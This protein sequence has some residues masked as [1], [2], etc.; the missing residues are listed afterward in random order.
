MERNPNKGVKGAAYIARS[1]RELGAARSIVATADGEVIA[2]N[3]V[4]E[5]AEKLGI[6]TR[7]VQTDGSE[8]V[9]V[10]RT[11]VESGSDKAMA[12]AIADNRAT[13]LNLEWDDE[14]LSDL[15]KTS[16]EDY[17]P[18]FGDFDAKKKE[19]EKL[20]EIKHNNV[21]YEPVEKPEVRLIDCIDLELFEKKLEY[22][23][24]SPISDEK[25]NIF[26]FFAY[27][28]IKIDF[29]EVANYYAFNATD[30]EKAVIERLRMV[31][32]D[33]GLNGFIE[34]HLLRAEPIYDENDHDC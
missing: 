5:Q 12:I 2:G 22:I 29:E 16:N 17:L 4:L 34:D 21:Y 15:K 6:P 26:K 20:S 30:E 33:S 24:R 14:I 32:T 11:D 8:L 19:T 23:N 9:V 25:K 28:F 27:R 31:L 13:E 1:L 10:Q 3:H 7:V 18:L